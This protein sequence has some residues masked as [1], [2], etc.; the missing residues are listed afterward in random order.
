MRKLLLIVFSISL[1]NTRFSQYTYTLN[2]NTGNPS[3]LNSDYEYPVGAGLDAS[4]TVIL[5][6]SQTTPSWSSTETIPFSF[7]FNGMLLLLSIKSH[8]LEF[9]LFL[10]QLRLFLEL[11]MLHYQV[12]QFQMHQFWFGGFKVLEQMIIL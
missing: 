10:Q 5:G 9:L 12:L 1:I 6:P 2:Q 7:N 3:G 8:L 4:W 11:L